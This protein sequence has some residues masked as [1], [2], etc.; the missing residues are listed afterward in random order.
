ME[1]VTLTTARLVLS[2]PTDADVDAIFGACQDRD[3]Q[4][5]TTVPQ[6]YEREHA[7]G[8]VA[9]SAQWWESGSE[10]TWAIRLNGALTGMVGLHHLGRGDAEIGYWMAS[11]YRKKGLLTE[12]CRAVVDWGFSTD[13]LGLARIEWRAVVGN[14]ASA[15]A[16]RTLGFRYEG[17]IRAA[18]AN[19]AG[20]RDDGWIAGLLPRDDRE[21]QQWDVLGD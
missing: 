2:P 10:A 11:A 21:P 3:I 4:R 18:L 19:G 9:K 6:P 8:F 13:G 15:R 7:V 20:R 16:A 1:P 14:T 5:Y 17:L 12:A